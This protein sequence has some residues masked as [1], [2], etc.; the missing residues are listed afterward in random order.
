MLRSTTPRP[1]SRVLHRRAAARDSV[2]AAEARNCRGRSWLPPRLKGCSSAGGAGGAGFEQRGSGS[3]RCGH[4]ARSGAAIISALGLP[5]LQSFSLASRC[6]RLEERPLRKGTRAH[7]WTCRGCC[8]EK[9]LRFRR[10]HAAAQIWRDLR[11]K[12]RFSLPSPLCEAHSR[13]LSPRCTPVK[14]REETNTSV[15]LRLGI[16]FA[17]FKPRTEALRAKWKHK[18]EISTVI[19]CEPQLRAERKSAKGGSY[20]FGGI[21][22]RNRDLLLRASGMGRERRAER[23]VA[24]WERRGRARQRVPKRPPHPCA[25][26]CSSVFAPRVCACCTRPTHVYRRQPV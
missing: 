19:F 26:I 21:D 6:P 13:V 4:A 22:A 18:S 20:W 17:R 10:A 8:C 24:T 25:G 23:E 16:M 5:L 14:S 7:F 15:C 12:V 2:K 3:C 11:R 9:Q 1:V